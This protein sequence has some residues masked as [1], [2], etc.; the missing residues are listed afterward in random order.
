MENLNLIKPEKVQNI[1]NKFCYTIGMIPTSYKISMT[2]EEQIIAIGHYLEETVIPALNNNAEAV[3][4]LQNLFI[5]L[6]NYVANYFD[7]L[8]VQ[9]EINNKLDQMV[10]DGTL[11]EIV[12]SYLNSKAIF[13]FDNVESMKNA[14][15]L[16]NGSYAKTLGYYSKNDDGG[17]LYKITTTKSETEYQETLNNGLYATLI[18]NDSINVKQLG[19]YGD[20]THDDT[21][22]LQKIINMN[23]PIIFDDSTYMINKNGLLLINNTRITFNNTILKMITNNSSGYNILN[24]NKCNN[25]N[26]LGNAYLIGDK[27]THTG[28]TGE[29]GHALSIIGSSNVYIENVQCSY[30][31]GDGCYIGPTDDLLNNPI[32]IIINNLVCH[33]NRR[34]GLSITSGY[35]IIINNLITYNNGGTS[36]N[37]GFDIEPYNANNVIDVTINNIYSYLNGKTGTGYQGFISNAYTDNYNVKIGTLKLDGVLS[38]TVSKEKSIVNID[39]LIENIQSTQTSSVLIMTMYGLINIKNCLID[40][41]NAPL[42]TDKDL[43][44][45]EKMLNTF[46]DNLSII[47]NGQSN[48]Y[49]ITNSSNISNFNINTLN[50]IGLLK[51]SN[52]RNTIIHISN[53]IKR[54]K[55]L[56]GQDKVI[57]PFMNDIIISD[58]IAS[59]NYNDIAQYDGY[60]MNI[61]N[62]NQETT[63]A[64][65]L[66]NDRFL[67]NGS[68]VYSISLP[69]SSYAKIRFDLFSRLYVV[70][71]LYTNS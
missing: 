21:E 13:G 40:I 34:I 59:I 35:K 49:F 56:T 51:I 25:V 50:Y 48:P 39:D 68:K 5:E 24:I 46:I 52:T 6:K 44:Y 61:Y 43:I 64:F 20:G 62:S 42:L 27:E 4:E 11:P 67:Y 54:S 66:N 33:H 47:N 14:T 17:A 8:D 29:F 71:Y 30:G 2:Y 57:Y 9:T 26:I 69:P 70:E 23:K 18:I 22:I 3:A 12:A 41:S 31:W 32:N 10:A 37:G 1:I 65:S 58:E 60:E 16:I 15:N 55:T 38:V 28:E 7:N 36:P 53:I 63:C 19:A 45:S